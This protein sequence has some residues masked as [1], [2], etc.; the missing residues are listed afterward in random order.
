MH[1]L[2]WTRLRMSSICFWKVCSKGRPSALATMP[3][4]CELSAFAV[5]SDQ[6]WGDGEDGPV[7]RCKEGISDGEGVVG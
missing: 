7:W 5:I 2:H 1:I 4:T 6:P 3:A